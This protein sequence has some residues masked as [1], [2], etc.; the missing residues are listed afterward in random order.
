MAT[1][2]TTLRLRLAIALILLR[3][4]A[5]RYKPEIQLVSLVLTAHIGNQYFNSATEYGV[6]FW[7]LFQKY[8]KMF[9]D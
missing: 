8:F 7:A 6:C 2:I 9:E 1:T 5:V 3:G 4:V